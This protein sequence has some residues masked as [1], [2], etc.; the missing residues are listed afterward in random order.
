MHLRSVGSLVENAHFGLVPLDGD[1]AVGFPPDAV[2]DHVSSE[3]VWPRLFV[4]DLH[5]VRTQPIDLAGVIEPFFFD[6]PVSNLIFGV[7]GDPA[8]FSRNYLKH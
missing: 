8:L 7:D 6:R 1:D 5:P 4:L 2:L 3:W